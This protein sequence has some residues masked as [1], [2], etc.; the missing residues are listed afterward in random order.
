MNKPTVIRTDND[1]EGL[2]SPQVASSKSE[3]T[4]S[5]SLEK[6]GNYQIEEEPPRPLTKL[7]TKS[8]NQSKSFLEM[9]PVSTVAV[10]IRK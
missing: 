8:I 7:K 10:I 1:Y 2:V 3:N 4:S 9:F 5:S 6:S